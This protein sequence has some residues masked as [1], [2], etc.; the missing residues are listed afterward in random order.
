MEIDLKTIVKAFE[1][2]AEIS[3]LN[4]SPIDRL[5]NDQIQFKLQESGSE[6]KQK[7]LAP[8]PNDSM[9]A[10]NTS[11]SNIYGSFAPNTQFKAST[12]QNPQ[13]PSQFVKNPIFNF[14]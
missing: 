1:G 2:F 10:T 5:F 6:K 11:S 13:S 8:I 7:P 12:V 14:D 9:F 3:K 4:T